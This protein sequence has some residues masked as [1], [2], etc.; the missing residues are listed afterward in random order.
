MKKRAVWM[1][2]ALLLLASGCGGQREEGRAEDSD[3]ALNTLYAGMEE[4]C[5]WEEGYMA[6]VEGEL[7]E[8]YYPG[9][10]GIPAKQ[11]VAKVPAMSSDVNEVVLIQCETEEDAESAAVI[12]QARI[13]AQAEGG[14][15]Y[16]ESL[17]AWKAAKVL[18]EGACAALIA[19]G[20]HQA[21]LEEQFRSQFQ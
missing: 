15:W 12:L 5:G 10:S 14:A 18:R 20:A 4:A 16:P 21:E 7:L 6:D 13:D 2:A 17:E 1:L 9:L 3:V 19:S 8:S 11:L